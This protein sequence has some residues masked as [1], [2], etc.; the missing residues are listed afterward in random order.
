MIVHVLDN[1]VAMANLELDTDEHND[2]QA[3]LSSIVGKRS[4][5]QAIAIM[6]YVLDTKFAMMPQEYKLQD[7]SAT[8]PSTSTTKADVE[9]SSQTTIS[10]FPQETLTDRYGKYVKKVLLHKGTVVKASEVS[11]RHLIP[12]VTPLPNTTN[13]YP[14]LAAEGF[15]KSMEN[16]GLGDIDRTANG[17]SI[18]LRKRRLE[19]MPTEA[20]NKLRKINITDEEY[21]ESMN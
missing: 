1:A 10:F 6:N 21:E 15:L 19:D 12:P 13:R 17:K 20:K 9:P 16:L 18:V 2:S 14:T 7:A 5:L 3:Q 4:A 8:A 11:G